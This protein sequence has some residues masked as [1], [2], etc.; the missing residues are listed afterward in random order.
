MGMSYSKHSLV[1]SF[2]GSFRFFEIVA[3]SAA[4]AFADVVAA[5]GP[6]ELIQ[7]NGSQ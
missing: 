1:V 2:D 6:C 4:A 7:S 3:I 5:Y